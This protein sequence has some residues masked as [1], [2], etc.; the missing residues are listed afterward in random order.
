[1]I[2]TA[3][4]DLKSDDL[5]FGDVNIG[6]TSTL[7]MSIE[8]DKNTDVIIYD[9]AFDNPQFA[10][11]GNA[12][13]VIPANTTVDIQVSYTPTQNGD[14]TGTIMLWSDSNGN[15]PGEWDLSGTGN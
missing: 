6:S 7:T 4:G 14:T 5:N 11:V 1:M 12:P 8:N 15:N 2:A 9:I 10:L 3:N 13:T